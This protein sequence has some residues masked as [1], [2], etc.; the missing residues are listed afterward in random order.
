MVTN[1]QSHSFQWQHNAAGRLTG[2]GIEG[3]KGLEV[4]AAL[5]GEELTDDQQ[6]VAR[7]LLDWHSAMEGFSTPTAWSPDEAHRD[8]VWVTSIERSAQLGGAPITL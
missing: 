1:N 7:C 8:L 4:L 6:A 5:P 3:I 2:L